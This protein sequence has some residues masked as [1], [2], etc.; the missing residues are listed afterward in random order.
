MSIPQLQHM[1]N[2]TDR[3]NR[4]MQAS[5]PGMVFI[6]VQVACKQQH[7]MPPVSGP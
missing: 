3:R 4:G 2:T 1:Y 6:A 7:V 5:K